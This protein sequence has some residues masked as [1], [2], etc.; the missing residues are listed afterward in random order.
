MA[1]AEPAGAEAAQLLERHIGHVDVE[2]ERGLQRLL[3][4]LRHQQA[5]H[6]CAGLEVTAARPAGAQRDRDASASPRKRPS[7]AAATVPEYSTSSPR[8]GP[9]FTPETTMSCSKSNSP[10]IA[11]C[12]QSV[13]VPGTK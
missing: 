13:G 12:T 7:T 11:R 10:E 9:S 5:R 4:Q 8:L 6:F 1:I 2:D 3:Q